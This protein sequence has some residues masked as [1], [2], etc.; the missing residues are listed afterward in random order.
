MKLYIESELDFDPATAWEI[1][2]SDE[3]GARL[4]QATDLVCTVLETRMEGDVK[5]R[6][7]RYA[8]KKD[9]PAIA[10]KAMGM[11]RLTYEQHN[12]FDAKKSQLSWQ[13]F[14]PVMTDRVS[15]RGKTTITA[16]PEGSRR[17]VDGD[18][19]VRVRLVGGQIEKTVVGEFEKSM[20]RA[21]D[22]ARQI[23]RERSADS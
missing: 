5:V 2:E 11:P 22:V 4:E 6:R 15:V 19:E 17:V 13:V 23:H 18:I 3:F 21:V 14:L 12:R 1:F 10:A 7:L 16:T 9:L 20:A 8:S